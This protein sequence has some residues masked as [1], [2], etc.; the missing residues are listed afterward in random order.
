MLIVSQA[1]HLLCLL[2][3]REEAKVLSPEAGCPHLLAGG[4]SVD[5]VVDMDLAEVLL[6]VG[7]PFHLKHPDLQRILSPPA[8][9]SEGK[10]L[11]KYFSFQVST[12]DPPGVEESFSDWRSIRPSPA[13]SAVTDLVLNLYRIY[14]KSKPGRKSNVSLP[15][16]CM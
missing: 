7:Q 13:G 11:G 2:W 15:T 9:N 8:K 16:A 3:K 5:L 12:C 14:L 1:S 6:V 10:E 4:A